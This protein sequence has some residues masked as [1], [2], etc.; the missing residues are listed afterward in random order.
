MSVRGVI[1]V[2]PSALLLGTLGG[3]GVSAATHTDSVHKSNKVRYGGT[4]NVG[5]D[6]AF[7]TLN[8]ALSSALIDRQAYINIFDPLLKL[9]PNMKIQP[10]LDTLEDCQRGQNL[11]AVLTPWGEASRWHAV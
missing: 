2:A 6:S 10:N 7:V 11:Y 9:S 5:I 3:P 1:T 8:P 4:L